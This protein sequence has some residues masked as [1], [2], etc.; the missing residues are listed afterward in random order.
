MFPMVH[1]LQEIMKEE[2]LVKLQMI[3]QASM[4][5]KSR[6][7]INHLPQRMIKVKMLPRITLLQERQIN[8]HKNQE[9]KTHLQTQMSRIN[10]KHLAQLRQIDQGTIMIKKKDYSKLISEQSNSKMENI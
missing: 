7:T 9:R 5:T 1:Q 4:F 2:I 6:Q 10:R 3:S 8:H